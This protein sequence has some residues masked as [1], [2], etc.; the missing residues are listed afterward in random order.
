[1]IHKQMQTYVIAQNLKL[2][3]RNAKIDKEE[4]LKQYFRR[5]W[6]WVNMVLGLCFLPLPLLATLASVL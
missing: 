4:I 3:N 1:M 6:C 5:N 2:R